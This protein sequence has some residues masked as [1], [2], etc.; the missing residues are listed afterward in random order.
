M[1]NLRFGMKVG[2]KLC[3]EVKP[4]ENFPSSTTAFIKS[5][6]LSLYYIALLDSTPNLSGVHQRSLIVCKCELTLPNILHNVHIYL[7]VGLAI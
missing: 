3:S 7:G 1:P 4:L 6:G 2:R 5:T